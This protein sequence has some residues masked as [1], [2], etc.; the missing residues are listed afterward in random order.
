MLMKNTKFFTFLVLITLFVTVPQAQASTNLLSNGSFENGSYN[1]NGNGSLEIPNGWSFVWAE[2]GKWSQPQSRVWQ[3]G[4]GGRWWRDGSHTFAVRSY[5]PPISTRL[6]QRVEGLN[7]GEIYKMTIPIWPEVVSYYDPGKTY[8]AA[9]D[10]A[11]IQVQIFSG[12]EQIFNSGLLDTRDFPVGRWSRMEVN[13][14]PDSGDLEVHISLRNPNFNAYNGF[15]LDGLSLKGTGLMSPSAKLA[16]EKL[17]EAEDLLKE[18]K[19]LEK[20][21][22][23]EADIAEDLKETNRARTILAFERTLEYKGEAEGLASQ[24][25]TLALQGFHDIIPL[26][27]ETTNIALKIGGYAAIANEAQAYA[28]VYAPEGN[29]NVSISTSS[30]ETSNPSLDG[31]LIIQNDTNQG[32]LIVWPSGVADATSVAA[33]STV[34]IAAPTGRQSIE[35]NG[36]SGRQVVSGSLSSSSKLVLS[37][38]P[39]PGFVFTAELQD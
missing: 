19:K 18:A 10:A 16:L 31:Q 27:T 29:A 12:G 32:M 1:W 6:A 8:S 11:E 36:P 7:P 2:D 35:I 9:Q 14:A 26:A 24:V 34:Q 20:K 30:D 13:I 17:E 28:R 5:G 3:S 33:N 37:Q 38:V 4:S 25:T 23:K 39:A 22:E 21:A 15:F